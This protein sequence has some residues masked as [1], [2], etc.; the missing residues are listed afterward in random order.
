MAYLWLIL[1]AAIIQA[2]RIE[3]K[4]GELRPFFGP[5][6]ST[7]YGLLQNVEMHRLNIGMKL[8]NDSFP[9]LSSPHVGCEQVHA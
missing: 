1:I 7:N 3:A 6:S 9:M 5:E 4:P 8:F 2:A